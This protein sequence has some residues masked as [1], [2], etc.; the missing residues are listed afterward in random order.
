MPTTDVAQWTC[1]VSNLGF[2]YIY[3]IYQLRSY[4]YPQP[5]VRHPNLCLTQNS[6]KFSDQKLLLPKGIGELLG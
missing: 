4:F 3:A 2:I 6:S 1:A 5:D